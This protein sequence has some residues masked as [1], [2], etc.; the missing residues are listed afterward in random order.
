M[1]HHQN[2][3]EQKEALKFLLGKTTSERNILLMIRSIRILAASRK[4]HGRE[5]P[6]VWIVMKIRSCF[7]SKADFCVSK[8]KEEFS[9]VDHDLIHSGRLI[10]NLEI[11]HLERKMIWTK[12]PWLCSI[13]IFSGAKFK[14]FCGIYKVHKFAASQQKLGTPDRRLRPSLW[15]G[16]DVPHVKPADRLPLGR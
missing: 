4:I 16:S 10:W 1:N 14:K 5:H 12:P 6:A 13:L 7:F 9:L 8:K 15:A 3:G 11:T 2:M